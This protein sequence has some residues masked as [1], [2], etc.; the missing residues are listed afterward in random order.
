MSSS[1]TVRVHDIAPYATSK[2]H[3]Y[4]MSP[5]SIQLRIIVVGAGLA[6]LTTACILKASGHEVTVLEKSSDLATG[7]ADIQI[8]PNATRCLDK[9]GLLQYI[10]H[11]GN[12]IT[13]F[14][15]RSWH[16]MEILAR[17]PL[18]ARGDYGF[19]CIAKIV[20]LLMTI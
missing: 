19:V 4:S 9:M 3:A 6:G 11:A 14:E 1:S 15:L 20:H 12:P 13:H 10:K 5:S 16:S 17:V 8:S 7:G 18:N 2:E